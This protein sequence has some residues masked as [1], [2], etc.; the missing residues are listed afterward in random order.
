Y[1]AVQLFLRR[2]S[3]VRRNFAPAEDEAR[4]VARICR[5][6]E[7]LPL[8][9]EL[10]AAALHTR[11]CTAI[12][13]AIERSSMGLSSE[14][15]AMPQRHRSIR[16][17]FEHSWRLLSAGEQQIFPRLSVFRGGFDQDAAAEVARA[18]P[19]TLAVLIDKSLLRWDGVARYDMHELLRQFAGE[20]LEQAGD[21]RQ[22][23]N[24]HLLHYL[25]LAES[26][27]SQLAGAEVVRELNRL[28][29]EHDNTRAGL[30]W[31][32]E[33]GDSASAL[34]LSAAMSKFWEVRGFLSEARQWL[35]QAL[36][37]S[38]ELGANTSAD[39]A[40]PRWSARALTQ[41]GRLAWCQ[42]DFTSARDLLEE[43]LN[44]HRQLNDQH[45]FNFVLG[46]LGGLAFDQGDYATA[47]T[48][49]EEYLASLRAEGDP[50]WVGDALFCV[51]IV[52]YNQ[53]EYTAAQAQLEESLTTPKASP[54]IWTIS[55]C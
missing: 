21:T 17:A 20:K 22:A 42:A 19:Q 54:R 46:I 2:A 24:A 38:R 48:R 35:E 47:R 51:G 52:A 4:A 16:A 33:Q 49:Y 5:L 15:R 29:V 45:G 9:I 27:E 30:R 36:T 55:S 13:D 6:V 8:A 40:L 1:S 10:A 28:D 12:A 37:L 53:G 31:A 25:T 7:G 34:R 43:S 50:R 3:Q 39:P 18:T 41:A 23:C 44:V 26:A 32:L 14:L 11:S